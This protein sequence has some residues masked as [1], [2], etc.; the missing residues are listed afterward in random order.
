MQ[1]KKEINITHY[2]ADASDFVQMEQ[3]VETYSKKFSTTKRGI[4][5]SRVIRNGLIVDLGE[6]ELQQVISAKMESA[7]ILHQLTKDIP[8]DLF[9][10]FHRHH[11]YSA[12]GG[13]PTTLRR[14]VF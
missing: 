3:I 7:W 2:S 1:E 12:P 6:E 4:S 10:F 11:Q 14:M 9:V 5:S 8:L 13:R